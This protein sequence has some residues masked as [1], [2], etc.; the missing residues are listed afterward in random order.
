MPPISQKHDLLA[1]DTTEAVQV[2][3]PPTDREH[4][5]TGVYAL[6]VPAPEGTT[7]DWHDVFHWQPATERPRTILLGGGDAVDTNPIYGDL[8]VY[9]GHDRLLANGLSLPSGITE[10]YVANHVRAILDLLYR[11]LNRYGRILNLTNVTTDWL[12]TPEQQEFVLVQAP[13][14]ADSLDADAKRALAAWIA[15]ERQRA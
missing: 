2:V 3:I 10:I 11:S 4:Y 5:I 7:G 14:M 13:R 8:G 9:E 12:N 1:F 15:G 6:N